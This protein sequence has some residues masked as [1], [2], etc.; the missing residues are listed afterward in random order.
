MQSSTGTRMYSNLDEFLRKQGQV[1]RQE[2]TMRFHQ[3]FLDCGLRIPKNIAVFPY[4]QMGVVHGLAL[5]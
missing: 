5:K 3:F 1:Q 2:Y 4:L